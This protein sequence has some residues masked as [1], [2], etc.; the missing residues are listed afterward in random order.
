MVPLELR[1]SNE[2]PLIDLT[3]RISQFQS[4]EFKRIKRANLD[5]KF[6]IHQSDSLG[7]NLRFRESKRFERFAAST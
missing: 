7:G 6:G 2:P 3:E 4:L 1:N 5:S